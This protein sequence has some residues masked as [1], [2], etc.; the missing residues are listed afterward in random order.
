MIDEYTI[1]VRRRRFWALGTD[2]GPEIYWRDLLKYRTFSSE[3]PLVPHLGERV[4]RLPVRAR[5]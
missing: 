2:D 5:R 4:S 3:W 1:H